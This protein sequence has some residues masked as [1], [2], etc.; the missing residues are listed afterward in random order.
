MIP[1]NSTMNILYS[2]KLWQIIVIKT[3]LAEK[4][5]AEWLLSTA[6]CELRLKFG[7]QSSVAKYFSKTPFVLIVY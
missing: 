7:D 3:F 2:T 1:E 4:T 5:L 6:Y